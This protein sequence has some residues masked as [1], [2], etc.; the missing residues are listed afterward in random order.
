[1][2]KEDIDPEVFEL[3]D[4]YFKK[5]L[6][7]GE[8][9]ISS[10]LLR[11]LQ[12]SFPFPIRQR[13][14]DNAIKGFPDLSDKPQEEREIYFGGWRHNGQSVSDRF[15]YNLNRHD[16][17]NHLLNEENI[18]LGLKLADFLAK[19]TAEIG[20][21]DAIQSIERVI[22]GFMTYNWDRFQKTGWDTPL[23]MP[24]S[25]RQP[26]FMNLEFVDTVY[27]NRFF[28]A[29]SIQA[30][31][32]A[33]T[34]RDWIT[35]Y[36]QICSD[37]T[38]MSTPFTTSKWGE[39]LKKYPWSDAKEHITPC[40]SN[41][42]ITQTQ[43]FLKMLKAHPKGKIKGVF[44]DIDG[45]LFESPGRFNRGLYQFMT[46]LSK[47]EKVTIFTGGDVKKQIERLKEAGVDTD[48]FPVVSKDKYRG[49]L[50]T[51]F[52][53]DD[54]PPDTQGFIMA[55]TQK[56]RWLHPHHRTMVVSVLEKRVKEGENL[57]DVLEDACL[58][59]HAEKVRKIV[60]ANLEASGDGFNPK[61]FDGKNRSEIAVRAYK[62]KYPKASFWQRL[63]GQKQQPNLISAEEVIKKF[64]DENPDRKTALKFKAL[65]KGGRG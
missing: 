4:S 35:R 1:M 53:I 36:A 54:T 40:D 22:D 63:L 65:K 43:E 30:F 32:G 51:G 19:K 31:L 46:E 49:Y 45:T 7:K 41:E 26:E 11:N 8:D 39:L 59:S 62:A 33:K 3:L 14:I 47:H 25:F 58:G 2:K 9:I 37:K 23:V 24:E 60:R 18:G 20:G 38:G 61:I 6:N 12:Q 27:N 44:V 56:R 5:C 15:T 52:I 10:D 55:E 64:H 28:M 48:K 13:F 17:E 21:K 50:F 29:K 57:E 42:S 16:S 34:I